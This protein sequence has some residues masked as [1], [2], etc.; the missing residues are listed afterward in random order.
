MFELYNVQ[1]V[2]VSTWSDTAAADNIDIIVCIGNWKHNHCV[3]LLLRQ[4]SNFALQSDHCVSF[5][6]FANRVKSYKNWI[7]QNQL[8]Y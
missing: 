7:E 2:H 4:M 5:R 8:E 3:I 1:F 6:G